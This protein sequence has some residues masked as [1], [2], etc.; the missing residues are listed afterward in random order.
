M[1]EKVNNK[2]PG[3]VLS[4]FLF[5]L[6]YR[7]IWIVFNDLP[8]KYLNMYDAA[9]AEDES[10]YLTISFALLYAVLLGL[11]FW[12]IIRFLKAKPDSVSCMRWALCLHIVVAYSEF[13]DAL[14]KAVFI[15]WHL[16]LG[17]V[18][19]LLL[20]IFML[21]YLAKSQ[22]IKRIFPKSE[23]SFKPGGLIWS[24]YFLVCVL[25]FGYVIYSYNFVM[26]R[27]SQP[28]P[29]SALAVPNGCYS[30]GTILFKSAGSWIEKT[31]VIENLDSKED[32]VTMY[33]LDS[34]SL[35]CLLWGGIS[36]KS[37]HCDFADLLLQLRPEKDSFLSSE[38]NNMDTL[39]NSD[40]YYLEQYVYKVDSVDKVW[41]FA[42]RFD[43]ESYKY[44]AMYKYG[45]HSKHVQDDASNM[46]EFL[47]TIEFD[48]TKYLRAQ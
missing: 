16:C 10:I 31:T 44:C 39:I 32:S 40:Q 18:L 34:D 25:T 8:V 23:R 37:R 6:F 35:D 42:V 1:E 27:K 48:L 38:T 22:E 45:K 46:M 47:K 19:A 30:D 24:F 21:I 5:L 43:K 26:V 3:F 7:L 33:R 13:R 17:P 15:S 2:V 12:S 20:Y 4:T 28:V 36:E 9:I 29:L 41:T 14:P 11:S